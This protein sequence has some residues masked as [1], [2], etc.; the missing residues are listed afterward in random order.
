[1]ESYSS[2]IDSIPAF[3]S[4]WEWDWRWAP[5]FTPGMTSGKEPELRS[6][7]GR[8]E[9]AEVKGNQNF[10]QNYPSNLCKEPC[11]CL[12]TSASRRWVEVD[13]AEEKTKSTEQRRWVRSR[14]S[15]IE[16]ENEW[17]LMEKMLAY[18]GDSRRRPEASEVAGTRSST[19]TGLISG[20]RDRARSGE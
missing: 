14:N 9:W 17:V 7:W 3:T 1:M 2:G 8:S 18:L 6:G 4:V 20:L 5:L 11:L 10:F 16:G 15:E 12:V 13:G 19:A